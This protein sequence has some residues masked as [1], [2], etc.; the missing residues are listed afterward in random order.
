MLIAVT[1]AV[2]SA[3]VLGGVVVAL[4]VTRHRIVRLSRVLADGNKTLSIHEARQQI[5]TSRSGLCAFEL[6]VVGRMAAWSPEMEALHGLDAGG[7][8]GS[9]SSMLA[10]AAGADDISAIE[11]G[12]AQLVLHGEA[13]FTYRI[14]DADGAERWIDAW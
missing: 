2:A 6:D 12:I 10:L 14:L 4:L 11:H 9:F 3:V 8:D 13:A 5:I 7:F 1:I